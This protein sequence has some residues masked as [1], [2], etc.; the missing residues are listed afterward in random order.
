MNFPPLPSAIWSSSVR[1]AFN[2]LN[3]IY[4]TAAAYIESGSVE[5]HRLEQYAVSVAGEG[6]KLLLL[7]EEHAEA[8]GIPANWLQR[9]A[10]A[11]V[12]LFVLLDENMRAAAGA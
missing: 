4:S 12:E 11:Y 6:F 7:L 10:N 9:A 3:N 8:E 1:K 2:K 5:S